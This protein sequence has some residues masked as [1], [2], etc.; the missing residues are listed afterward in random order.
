[1]TDQKIFGAAAHSIWITVQVIPREASHQLPYQTILLI[2]KAVLAIRLIILKNLSIMASALLYV[3]SSNICQR[4]SLYHTY[5][6]VFVI[7]LYILGSH[8]ICCFLLETKLLQLLVESCQTY[9]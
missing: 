1:M 5:Q 8:L 2:L 6:R 3:A 7:I 9:I 4:I